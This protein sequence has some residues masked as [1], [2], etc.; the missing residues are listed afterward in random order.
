M[1]ASVPTAIGEPCHQGEYDNSR[2]PTRGS[3]SHE[4]VSAETAFG[5]QMGL[6]GCYSNPEI[7][8]RL[9]RLSD[10]LERLVASNAAPRPSHR[11]DKRLR[12]GLVPKAIERVLRDALGPM[13]AHD[14]HAGV[15]EVL[16][17][18]VPTS[19]VKNWL[20]KQAQ[21]EQPEILRLGRGRY[22]LIEIP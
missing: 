7:Q 20:A 13:Q 10:K 3:I 14:I 12:S 22:R 9:R 1:G 2:S 19:S 16:G 4:M 6:L 11:Q 5:S 21:G 8:G 18:S 15:E 17:R